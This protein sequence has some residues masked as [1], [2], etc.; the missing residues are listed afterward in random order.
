MRAN[1]RLVARMSL[2]LAALVGCAREPSEA[3]LTEADTQ[4]CPTPVVEGL[5][6]YS[7]NGSIDWPSVAASGRQFAFIKVTQGNYDVQSTLAADWSGALAAGVLRSPY[8]FFDG[9]IDG[10]TQAN[11]FLAALGSAGGL[12][13]GDLPPM[14]DLECPTSSDQATTQSDCEYTGDSGWVATATLQQRALDWLQTVQQATGVAPILYSYPSWFA[15]TGMTATELTNYP[16]FIAT[17]EACADVPT[18]WTTAAFWQYSATGTVP[19][20]TGEV[21]ED[22]FFGSAA[23][24]AQLTVHTT[25]L[26]HD[27]GVDAPVMGNGETDA[28]NGH[29]Q[30][31]GGCGCE[32]G[33]TGAGDLAF[34]CLA[35]FALRRRPRLRTRA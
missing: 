28:G 29:S 25:T 6:V 9:T 21:D 22:R 14:L 10:V 11:W 33:R 23:A 13:P 1:T 31:V 4:Y 3:S 12:Q 32:T 34:A 27:A 5:D 24:L 2:A 18:P 8:H 35:M 7:G 19:G 30:V 16:L 17:Y 20:V 15:D 26:P